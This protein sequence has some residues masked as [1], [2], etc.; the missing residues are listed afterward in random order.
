[1]T[2]NVITYPAGIYLFKFIIG[3]I[4]KMCEIILNL[5]I[6]AP[7][8]VNDVVLV[9]LF[10]TLSRCLTFLSHLL[11]TS[12]FQ[13]KLITY[14]K[15]RDCCNASRRLIVQKQSPGLQKGALKKFTKLKHLCQSLWHSS[16]T[17]VFL[18]ILQNF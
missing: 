17:G 11:W 14:M 18:W 13:G 7:H 10:L 16:G 15:K 12:S 2:N 8:N 6:K 5:T 3:N 4:K 9:S 1:M